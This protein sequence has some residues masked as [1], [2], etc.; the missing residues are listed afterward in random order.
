VTPFENWLMQADALLADWDPSRA[1]EL[2][3]LVERGLDLTET[4]AHVGAPAGS[5]EQARLQVALARVTSGL[6]ARRDEVGD[7]LGALSRQ[8]HDLTRNATGIA[9]YLAADALSPVG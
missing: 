4:G 7:Q 1:D 2:D 6:A 8:R 9:G 5:P 3:E